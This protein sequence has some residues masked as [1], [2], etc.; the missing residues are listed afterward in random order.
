MTR[1]LVM[2]TLGSAGAALLLSVLLAAAAPAPEP[3][4]KPAERWEY[5]ELQAREGAALGAVPAPGALPPAWVIQWIT[6]QEVVQA[7]GWDDMAA[8]MK[9]APLKKDASL[10]SYKVSIF[11][12]LGSEGWEMV[13]YHKPTGSGAAAI[14]I[15]VFKRKVTK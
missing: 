11:N 13:S 10:L 8:R 4:A 3:P 14:S 2:A 9:V 6:T 1:L 5:C 15:W 7:L 12:H